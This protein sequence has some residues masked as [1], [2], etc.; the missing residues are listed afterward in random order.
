MTEVRKWC[1]RSCCCAACRMYCNSSEAAHSKGTFTLVSAVLYIPLIL[2][3]QRS[4]YPCRQGSFRLMPREEDPC[5]IQLLLLGTRHEARW[6]AMSCR[7][8]LSLRSRIQLCL[9]LTNYNCCLGWRICQNQYMLSIRYWENLPVSN[10]VNE[11]AR[12]KVRLAVRQNS[13]QETKSDR[14]DEG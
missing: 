9:W 14:S 13:S 2:V 6:Q 3:A 12:I 11:T 7:S 5:R 10:K 1:Q 4:D 8:L